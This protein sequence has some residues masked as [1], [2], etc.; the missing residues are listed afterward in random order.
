MFAGLSR[1]KETAHA[2]EARGQL[3]GKNSDCNCKCCN[4]RIVDVL[5]LADRPHPEQDQIAEIQSG[6]CCS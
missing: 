4:C 5:S 1:R 2:L 3:P 6:S